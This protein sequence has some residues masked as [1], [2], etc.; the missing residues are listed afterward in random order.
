MVE[1]RTAGNLPVGKR[2]KSGL[3][4]SGAARPDGREQGQRMVDSGPAALERDIMVSGCRVDAV[5]PKVKA[6][7]MRYV[8]LIVMSATLIGGAARASAQQVD[9]QI[10]IGETASV[11]VA[12][13]VPVSLDS[14]LRF[15]DSAGGL[16]QWARGGFIGLRARDGTELMVGYQRVTD[17]ADGRVTRVEQRMREQASIGL[18]KLWGGALSG[19]LRV[20][21]RFRSGY[22]AMGLRTRIQ[23][24]YI[25]P[26]GGHGSP[27]L[28]LSHESFVELNDT[29]W[30]QRA[31]VR[32]M[33]NQIGL[34]VPLARGL[35]L[36]PTYLN[37]YDF[38]L[39][40]KRDLMANV[41]S[42]TA[43]AHF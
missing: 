13:H 10:W 27:A 7:R 32:R 30:G 31:G 19:R 38:A 26:L 20:E 9:T 35:R 8:R 42:L 14:T 37:Q 15:G 12:K 23:F 25:H 33:R 36:Q 29:G 22:N 5:P 1:L 40:G 6:C 18:G 24:R 28:L 41:F 2:G 3:A 43:N 39:P 4:A 16:Y 34:D 11:D 21:E 17:Y